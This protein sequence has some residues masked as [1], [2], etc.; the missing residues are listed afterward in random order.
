[1]FAI[2]AAAFLNWRDISTSAGCIANEP[3]NFG[4]SK[5]ARVCYAWA[6]ESR[7]PRLST[8]EAGVMR[9]TCPECSWNIPL[10][11]D[12]VHVS[13]AEAIQEFDNHKREGCQPEKTG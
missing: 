10:V 4:A 12:N 3:G 11:R 9:W 13:H 6:V 5:T 1:M 2:R 8:D 7:T